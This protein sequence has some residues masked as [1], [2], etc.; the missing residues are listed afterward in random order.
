[1]LTLPVDALCINRC[2]ALAKI[3]AEGHEA[4]VLEGMKRLLVDCHPVLIVETDSRE[5]VATLAELGYAPEK[6]ENSPNILF[7]PKQ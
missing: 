7:R 1:M 5:V 3:D 4:F 6:L 2:I